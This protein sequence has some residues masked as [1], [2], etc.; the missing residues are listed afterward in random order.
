MRKIDDRAT[1]AL[2]VKA[3]HNGKL[4]VMQIKNVTLNISD[5][6]A[7]FTRIAA[8]VVMFGIAYISSTAKTIL[9]RLGLALVGCDIV[10]LRVLK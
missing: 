1:S 4:N 2:T 7:V 10:L 5:R 8:A 9:W 3:N 6:D